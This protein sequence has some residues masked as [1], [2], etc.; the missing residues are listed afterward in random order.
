MSFVCEC[1]VGP[2]GDKDDYSIAV[3]RR[4]LI[5]RARLP[6]LS[7]SFSMSIQTQGIFIKPLNRYL[8]YL[9]ILIF[10]VQASKTS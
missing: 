3:G 4:S 8:L 2:Y 1:Y 7:S 9:Q 6:K 10:W 5:S